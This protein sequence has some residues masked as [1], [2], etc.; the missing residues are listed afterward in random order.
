MDRDMVRQSRDHALH[1]TSSH[2]P[3]MKKLAQTDGNIPSASSIHNQITNDL[4]Q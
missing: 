3:E 1:Q 4:D 2:H